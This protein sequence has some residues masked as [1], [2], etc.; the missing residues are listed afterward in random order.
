MIIIV[1]VQRS[2]RKAVFSSASQKASI[3]ALD[4]WGLSPTASVAFQ[5]ILSGIFLSSVST[6]IVIVD[7]LILKFKGG[8][9]TDSEVRGKC[10]IASQESGLSTAFTI[11]LQNKSA[12][13]SQ[14]YCSLI[15]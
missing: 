6:S 7:L 2:M 13:L 8:K 4:R 11:L 14:S 10:A 12:D 5:T 3:I 1:F 9:D 15:F